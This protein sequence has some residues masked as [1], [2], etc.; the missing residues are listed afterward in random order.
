MLFT[1]IWYYNPNI[2]SI[3]QEH[4]KAHTGIFLMEF[5]DMLH[6]FLWRKL[7]CVLHSEKSYGWSQCFLSGVSSQCETSAGTC[8]YQ[9]DFIGITSGVSVAKC[10]HIN[11]SFCC[12]IWMLNIHV[13]VCVCVYTYTISYCIYL[14]FCLQRYIDMTLRLSY[15]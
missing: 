7:K 9:F 6:V 3:L 15:T 4:F 14:M 12:E 5:E 10:Q 8:G 2:K 1:I 13:C 11:I